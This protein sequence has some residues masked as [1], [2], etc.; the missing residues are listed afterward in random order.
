MKKLLL[1]A[2][3]ALLI[4]LPAQSETVYLLI[5]SY[6]V[7]NGIGLAL[8]SLPMSSIDQC[9]EMGALLIASKRFDLKAANHEAYECLTGK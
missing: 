2:S 1:L 8:H 5:K 6:G 9:E 3:S 4:G 7:V